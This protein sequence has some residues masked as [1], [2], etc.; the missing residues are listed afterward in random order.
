MPACAHQSAVC[1]KRSLVLSIITYLLKVFWKQVHQVWTTLL[2]QNPCCR[3]KKCTSVTVDCKRLVQNKRSRKLHHITLLP[4]R[5]VH[6]GL[7]GEWRTETS[8]QPANYCGW[9]S[10]H[11]LCE[12]TTGHELTVDMCQSVQWYWNCIIHHDKTHTLW[13][14]RKSAHDGYDTFWQQYTYGNLRKPPKCI[15]VILNINV[16]PFFTRSV[17]W[18]GHAP[19]YTNTGWIYS[20]ING[21]TTDRLAHKNYGRNRVSCKSCSWW[22]VII[23]VFSSHML[24]LLGTTLNTT[25]YRNFWAHHLHH[26]LHCRRPHLL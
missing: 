4:Y 13:K 5:C 1:F 7:G 24:S 22:L 19:I 21:V 12:D 20:Q 2:Y 3:S 26:T 16:R 9:W 15:W 8:S 17:W 11:F 23:R 25:D 6:C 18:T 10:L 14:C